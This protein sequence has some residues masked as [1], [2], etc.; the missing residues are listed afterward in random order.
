MTDQIPTPA[1][2]WQE[3][4][5]LREKHDQLAE[6]LSAHRAQV[7]QRHEAIIDALDNWADHIQANTA[8]RVETAEYIY[9]LQATLKQWYHSMLDL[10]RMVVTL[11]DLLA[12]EHGQDLRLHTIADLP[13]IGKQLEV[14]GAEVKRKRVG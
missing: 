4:L 14:N 5:T 2:I 11:Y 13:H 12:P 3:L 6:A 1:E 7:K 10:Q 9:G 8:A